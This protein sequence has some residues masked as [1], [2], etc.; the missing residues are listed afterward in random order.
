MD[1]NF[2]DSFFMTG[3]LDPIDEQ[4]GFEKINLRA[5]IRGDNWDLMFYGRNITDEITASG[6]FDV[7]LAAGSHARYMES[8]ELY[9]ARFSYSF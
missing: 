2:T 9:G 3:D 4:V 6:A 8:G 5:G 7:P 1:I